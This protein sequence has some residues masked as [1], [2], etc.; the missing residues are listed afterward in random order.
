MQWMPSTTSTSRCSHCLLN[1]MRFLS[2]RRVTSSTA[3][4]SMTAKLPSPLRPKEALWELGQTP[5]GPR[6]ELVSLAPMRI[7]MDATALTVAA[8]GT[9]LK[10]VD[11][12]GSEIEPSLLARPQEKMTIGIEANGVGI[13]HLAAAPIS[14]HTFPPIREMMELDG[15]MIGH[16]VMTGLPAMTACRGMTVCLEMTACLGM[17]GLIGTTAPETSGHVMTVG[18]ATAERIAVTIEIVER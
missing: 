2:T 16:H 14:T 17:I 3:E 18:G 8:T 10:S 11:R 12:R 9:D 7:V 6:P 1:R 13:H 15:E 5:M 4:S